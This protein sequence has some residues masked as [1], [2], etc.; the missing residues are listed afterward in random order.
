[1]A[2]E[3]E[4]LKELLK[5]HSLMFGDFTL[6]SGR[7]S[8]YYFDSKKTTLLP[9]GAHLAARE[10][11]RTLRENGIRADAIGGLTLG[12]D[13][14]VCPVA[15]LSF[16][17]GPPM[18]AF[19]VRKEAK[20][21]G[22]GRRIEGDVP[23]GSRVVIVD[24]VVTTAGSTLK[25]IDARRK[26]GSRSSPWC[27]SWTGKRAARRSS[28]SGRSSRCSAGRRSSKERRALDR[29]D[30]AGAPGLP[31][32]RA[33]GLPRGGALDRGVGRGDPV[34]PPTGAAAWARNGWVR[35]AVSGLGSWTSGS[36]RRRARD[37]FASCGG[38]RG[39]REL[40][41][42]PVVLTVH[43]VD[44]HG[45]E[46]V[47]ADAATFA[48]LECRAVQVVTSVLVA[49]AA[50][51]RRSRACRSRWSR[52]SSSR[53]PR[54]PR[55][56]AARTGILRDP[57]QVDLV[58]TLL[59]ECGAG[60]IVVAPVARVGATRI[61][62]DATWEATRRALFPLATVVLVRAGDLPIL[63][64]ERGRDLEGVKRG[65]AALRSQGPGRRSSRGAWG[66]RVLDV[67][68]DGG[69]VAVF[70][71]S[72]LLA[73]RVAGVGGIHA[74]ALAAFLPGARP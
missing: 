15:A 27:V 17:E 24:D 69:P 16:V 6:A 60:S 35:G 2:T 44:T 62:D 4:R 66:G 50:G 8:K 12:A 39:R 59:R 64:G 9:E 63:A 49:S 31:V 25:A 52:S 22:T 65:A 51:P 42:E 26:P 30:P 45:E 43:A 5:K 33:G 20:E 3:R 28:R 61:L 23:A 37:C 41:A 58:A 40:S 74:A 11:L 56:A 57:L 13:P 29:S 36:P 38:A 1:M 19:I 68:D 73:P 46:G 47:T 10:I 54:R 71:A 18:R 21:H 67:L 14:I 34:P 55:P 48:D 70:D 72:R 32:R 53:W 7:R